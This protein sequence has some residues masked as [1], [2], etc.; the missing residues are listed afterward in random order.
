MNVNSQHSAF[1]QLEETLLILEESI[2]YDVFSNSASTIHISRL[3]QFYSPQFDFEHSESGSY[4]HSALICVNARFVESDAQ[5]VLPLSDIFKQSLAYI[6]QISTLSL[7]VSLNKTKLTDC[8]ILLAELW[9]LSTTLDI[10]NL[11]SQSIHNMRHNLQ[12]SSYT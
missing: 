6:L 2:S 9:G 11:L 4:F 12:Q 7:N 8:L 5:Y 3:K 1:L 10:S